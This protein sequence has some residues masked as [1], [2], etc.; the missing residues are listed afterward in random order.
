MEE[1]YSIFLGEGFGADIAVDASGSAYVTGSTGSADF[2]TTPGAFQSTGG[3]GLADGFTAKISE[4]IK[5]GADLSILKTDSP[6]PIHEG[7]NLTYTIV[8][9]NHG[10]EKATNVVVTDNM[11]VKVTLISVKTTQGN[12]SG[13]TTVICELGDME[14]GSNATMTLVGTYVKCESK[15]NRS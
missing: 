2:P 7:E 3:G 4:R 15:R 1:G 11:P 13:T 6:D 9:T 12:C 8:V 5:G 14:N 10:P